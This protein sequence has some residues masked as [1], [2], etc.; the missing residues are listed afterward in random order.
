[1]VIGL[2]WCAVAAVWTRRIHRERTA[3]T[4]APADLTSDAILRELEA[5][6]HAVRD[7]TRTA[8]DA[9]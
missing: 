9:R 8:I 3:A 4:P 5:R 7:K 2:G 6:V 1:V